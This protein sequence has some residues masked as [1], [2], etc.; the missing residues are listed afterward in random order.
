MVHDYRAENTHCTG[1]M[2]NINTR[3]GKQ[4]VRTFFHKWAKNYP[5]HMQ[6][7]CDNIYLHLFSILSF[8]EIYGNV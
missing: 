3:K 8:T 1:T 5:Q 6:D 2:S 7:S 4:L